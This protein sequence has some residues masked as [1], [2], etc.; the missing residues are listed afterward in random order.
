MAGQMDI[1]NFLKK[2]KT[3]WFKPNVICENIGIYHKNNIYRKLKQLS[4]Y[5]YILKRRINNPIKI[6][7]FGYDAR[8]E[9]CFVGE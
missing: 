5:N 6:S 3:K 4:K 7:Q 9:Y 8:H 2:H 1:V